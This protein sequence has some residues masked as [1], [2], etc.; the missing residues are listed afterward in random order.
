MVAPEKF[1]SPDTWWDLMA[2]HNGF[3]VIARGVTFILC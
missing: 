1:P 3:F 2:A